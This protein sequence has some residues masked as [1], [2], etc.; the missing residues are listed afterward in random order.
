MQNKAEQD[1]TKQNILGPNIVKQNKIAL[2]KVLRIFSQRASYPLN[3]MEVVTVFDTE[4]EEEEEGAER[5]VDFMFLGMFGAGVAEFEVE[6]EV[7][8]PV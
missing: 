7:T 4:E 3:C 1:R 5:C 2:T 8:G 6:V